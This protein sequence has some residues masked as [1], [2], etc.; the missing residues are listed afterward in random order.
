MRSE[1]KQSKSARACVKRRGGVVEERDRSAK[2]EKGEEKDSEQ[3]KK[4]EKASATPCG[5]S[6]KRKEIS[7]RYTEATEGW[8]VEKKV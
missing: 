6:V 4:K 3:K 2:R 8:P 7:E 5:T 1:I